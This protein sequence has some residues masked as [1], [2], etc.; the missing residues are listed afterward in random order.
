MVEICVFILRCNTVAFMWF[1][2]T[3]LFSDEGIVSR[4]V[5]A[6]W[7]GNCCLWDAFV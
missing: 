3:Y 5:C 7:S 2:G 4:I 1:N 6:Y